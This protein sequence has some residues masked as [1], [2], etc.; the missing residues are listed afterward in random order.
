M[1]TT[2]LLSRFCGKNDIREYLNTPLRKG[3]YLYASNGHIAVRVVDE[4]A[5]EAFAVIA[6]DGGTAIDKVVSGIEQMLADTYQPDA[7]R[8]ADTN[9]AQMLAAAEPCEYCKGTGVTP[10]CERCNNTGLVTS[11]SSL[12]ECPACG[13]NTDAPGTHCIACDGTG[14]DVMEL[15]VSLGHA[16]YNPRYIALLAELPNATLYN[17]EP[18]DDPY[19]YVPGLV[20]FDGGLALV[21]PMIPPRGEVAA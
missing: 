19:Y 18:I 8:L 3:G 1:N 15:R 13:G 10:K 14:K 7:H 5:V 11:L 6:L 20:R 9:A 2:E 12:D 17:A 16:Y 21:M 4:P